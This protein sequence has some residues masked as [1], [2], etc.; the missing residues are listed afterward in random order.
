MKES[1]FFPAVELLLKLLPVVARQELFAL[2]G[3]TAINLFY[4]D[5]PRLSV[6]IDLIY[7]PVEDRKTSLSNITLSMET[8]RKDAERLIRG[9][10]VQE[11]RVKENGGTIT[12]LIVRDEKAL[13]KVEPN[14][15]LRG[16]VYPTEKR[17]IGDKVKATFRTSFAVK[18]ASFADLY[19]GKICAALDRQHPRDLFDIKILL[20][21]EGI[22]D[23]IRKA[24]VVY[25]ISHNRPMDELLQPNLI[26]QREIF[27]TEFRT[28]TEMEISYDELEEA[29]KKLISLIQKTLTRRERG[30]ILSIAEGEP[31][32]SALDFQHLE[33]LPAI[34]WKLQNVRRMEEKKRKAACR[35]LCKILD[36]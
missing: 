17:I 23:K 25:L 32:W 12:R 26:D 18:C 1:R 15:I 30:F 7:L 3:G 2:K 31:D 36:L 11:H 29:R 21:H 35:N 24:F 33:K 34:Q 27:E 13:V 4:R 5:M 10:T 6:D 14:T 20:E 16:T 22:T 28:M 19:G 9:I 8:I